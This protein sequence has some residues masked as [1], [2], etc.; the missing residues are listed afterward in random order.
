MTLVTQS[1]DP[2]LHA[3]LSSSWNTQRNP[4]WVLDGHKHYRVLY[5]NAGELAFE[6]IDNRAL[7]DSRSITNSKRATY[8]KLDQ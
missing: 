2:T 8:T 7:Y 4:G 5:N 3:K 1:S 6:L